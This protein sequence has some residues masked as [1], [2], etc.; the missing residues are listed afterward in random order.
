MSL[1]PS[2]SVC[3]LS[4]IAFSLAG[5]ARA[6][7]GAEALPTVEVTGNYNNGVGTSDAASQGSVNAKLIEN[8]PTLAAR[9]DPGIR[10]RPD[11]LAAQRRRQGEPVLPARLQPRPRHRLRDL[12]RRHAD[13]HAHARARAGLHR[14]QF[15]DPRAGLAHRLQERPLLRG[16]GR[17]RVGRC[18]APEPGRLA[19]EGHRIG[20]GRRARLRAGP[21]RQLE[22][23]RR[24]PAAL[25]GRCELQQRAVGQP[26]TLRRTSGLLRY[27]QG[28]P[29]DGF[30]ITAM[31]YDAQLEQHRPDPAA[32]RG[33]AA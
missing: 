33:R 18:G 20:H 9:R 12:R 13:Q 24:R 31:A 2:C 15:P 6:D 14:P 16:R 19:G 23:L 5:A 3:L 11:R 30:S 22:R 10:A 28:Q 32:R 8:R 17:L 29:G 21:D 4:S 7:D 1:R 26:G 25:C 27:S